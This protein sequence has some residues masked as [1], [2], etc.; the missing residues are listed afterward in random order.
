[1]MFILDDY[2]NDYIGRVDDSDDKTIA[3]HLKEIIPK[4]SHLDKNTYNEIIEEL[5]KEPGKGEVEDFKST[6]HKVRPKY[7]LTGDIIKAELPDILIRIIV[8][9]DLFLEYICNVTGMK[10][11]IIK[12]R[13][14]TRGIKD[15]IHFVGHLELAPKD[16]NVVFATFDED[17]PGNDPFVNHKAIDIINRLALSTKNFEEGES[18]SVIKLKYK[19]LKS[20]GKKFPIFFDAGWY[21]KFFP[22][23]QDDKYGRTRSLD[24][25]LK[26]MPEIV[27]ENVKISEM[28]EDIEF[29]KD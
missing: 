29:L 19:N 26:N 1:M 12:K 6:F 8:H 18:K 17:T 24:N 9:I 21:E 15:F 25:S 23:D 3:L 4:T 2:I 7:I 11:E 28:A 13:I 10:V 5:K 22:S 16:D 14:S 27:H 20:I